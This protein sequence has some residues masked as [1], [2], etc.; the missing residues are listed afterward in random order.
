MLTN[1]NLK[2]FIRNSVLERTEELRDR[3]LGARPFRY[4]VIDDF[5]VGTVVDS[6][7]R[8]FPHPQQKDMINEYGD[9][10]L[11]HTV[12]NVRGIGGV[13]LEIDDMV[14]S[15]EFGALLEKITGIRDLIYDPSYYGGGTHNNLS[16]QGMD[17]HVDFNLLD[18]PQLGT[19][20]RRINAILYL[21]NDWREE[22]GGNLDLHS[23]PWEPTTDKIIRVVP[24][25]NRLVIFE[26]NEVSWHGFLPVKSGIPHGVSRKSFAIYMYTKER[27]KE[28]VRPRH[29]TFYV[30]RIPI[31]ILKEGDLV[32]RDVISELTQSRSHALQMIKNLYGQ[33]MKLNDYVNDRFYEIKLLKEEISLL[34]QRQKP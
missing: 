12:T 15:T 8:E 6:M 16:G 2:D 27:P 21:N 34:R 5:L 19:F 14:A 31:E 22:Y 20:H 17:P 9:P 13:Y 10:S 32:T 18:I 33:E 26:T 1:M 24:I 7:V 25:K 23:N 11:K 30:P 29:G 28:E 4:L 3:F